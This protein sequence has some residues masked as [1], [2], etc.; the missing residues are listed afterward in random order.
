MKTHPT[1]KISLGFGL[2]FLAV[3]AWWLVAQ[4][5]DLAPPTAGW[6][7]A[8]ALIVFGVLG[9]LG[10]LRSGRTPE[11]PADPA[12]PATPAEPAAGH[13]DPPSDP[14]PLI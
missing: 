10:A 4:L 6:F 2:V 5:L 7:L 8:V 13:P 9:L 14:R 11:P 12:E 1:D 3:A